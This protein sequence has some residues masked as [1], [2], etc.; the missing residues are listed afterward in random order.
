MK[1][2]VGTE[3]KKLICIMINASFGFVQTST[4]KTPQAIQKNFGTKSFARIVF[5]L[6]GIQFHSLV[7]CKFSQKPFFL[8]YRIT[9]FGPTAALGFNLIKGIHKFGKNT[10]RNT[11][12][13]PHFVNL[14]ESITVTHGSIHF[15]TTPRTFQCP[16]L[17]R[18]MAIFLL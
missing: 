13:V 1:S 3:S 6:I 7:L 14:D 17:I 9:P 18:M 4:K 11:D 15:H 8:L 10:R 12:I 2:I 5:D 16:F